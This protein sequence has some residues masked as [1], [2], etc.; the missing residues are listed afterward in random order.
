MK[1]KLLSLSGVAVAAMFLPAV[2]HAAN[3]AGQFITTCPYDHSLPDDPVKF[4]GKPGASHLHDFL[5]NK[6][7]KASSTYATMTA[8]ATTCGTPGDTAGYW[9]PALYKNGVKINPAGSFGGRNTREKFYYTA[10]HYLAGTKVEPFPPGFAMIRG[11]AMATSVAD[12]NAHGARWGT[13][14]W[15]G[16]ADNSVGGKPTSPPN[17]TVGII[18]AHVEFPSCWDGVTVAGD[19]I[20]AGHVKDASG[21]QCPTGF[22][23]HLPMLVERIEYPV[24]T[25]SSGI[26]LSSGATYTF[27]ADFWQTWQQSKLNSLVANCLSA[28]VDCGTNPK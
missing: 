5:G 13:A 7:T 28:G 20:A 15:W 24:G 10:N 14:M 9:A 6:T 22:P 25:S 16:C 3:S 19:E 26:T 12:A 17:C 27:H 11:Y 18:T 23:H 1:S 2:A 4:P 21:G 8:G